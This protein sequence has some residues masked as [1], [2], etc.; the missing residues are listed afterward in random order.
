MKRFT[1]SLLALVLII[2]LAGCGDKTPEK[3]PVKIV[4][5]VHPQSMGSYTLNIPQ[6]TITAIADT[7]ITKVII[8]N[9]NGCPV[10]VSRPNLPYEMKYGDKLIRT[11]TAQCNVMKVEVV[12]DNGQWSVEY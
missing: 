12:T 6:I 9:G 8:N 4:T 1:T 2:G 3:S 10:S 11:Y 7:T 5:K